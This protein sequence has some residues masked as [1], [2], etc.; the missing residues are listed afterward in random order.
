MLTDWV[1]SDISRE[2]ENRVHV[3][4]EIA[5]PSLFAKR[6]LGD[7][8]S[9]TPDDAKQ[10]QAWDKFFVRSQ[11]DIVWCMRLPKQFEVFMKEFALLDEDFTSNLPLLRDPSELFPVMAFEIESASGKHAGGGILNLSRYSQF[12]FVVVPE[13]QKNAIR[14]KI[15]TLSRNMGINNVFSLTWEE[16]TE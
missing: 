11:L 8:I 3:L 14:G 10:I 4:K 5:S 7:E 15:N 2:Y 13:K 1:P 6:Y 12:G 9:W 16:L